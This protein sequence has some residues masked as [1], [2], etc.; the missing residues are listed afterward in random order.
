[1]IMDTLSRLEQLIWDGDG[2]T[3][4]LY[5]SVTPGYNQYIDLPIDTIVVAQSSFK[6]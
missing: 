1:M 2:G 3:I 5:R 4:S 6:D